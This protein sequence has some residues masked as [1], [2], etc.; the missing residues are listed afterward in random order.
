[1]PA[2]RRAPTLDAQVSVAFL[3]RRVRGAIAEIHDEGRR[4]LVVTEED[5]RIEFR[6]SPATG[7]FTS[8]AGRIGARLLFEDDDGG[9]GG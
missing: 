8:S 9:P 6:L 7:V 2:K 4:L 5:E 3:G 1:M